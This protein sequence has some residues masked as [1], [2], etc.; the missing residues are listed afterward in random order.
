MNRE[1]RG[2]DEQTGEESNDIERIKKD[3]KKVSKMLSRLKTSAFIKKIIEICKGIMHCKDFL[4]KLDQNKLLIGCENG[5]LDLETKL[6]RAG[7]PDDFISFSTKI[8]YKEFKQDD[9]D[10]KEFEDFCFKIFPNKNRR[11]YFLD[12][13]CIAMQGGNIN[14]K[15]LAQTG[16]GNNGKSVMTALIEKCFGDYVIKFPREMIIRGKGNSSSQARPELVRVKGRRFAILQEVASN[17]EL[18]VGVVKELTGND[19]FF[20]RGMYKDGGEITPMFTLMMQCNKLP[21]IP[22]HDQATWNRVRV[23]F[24]ESTFDDEAPENKEEQIDKRHFE[25]DPEFSVKIPQ[26]SQVMLWYLFNRFIN[27]KSKKIVEPKEVTDA[28]EEYRNDCDIY[29]Q[30][31]SERINKMHINSPDIHKQTLTIREVYADFIDWYHEN[32][33]SY[34]KDKIGLGTFRQN[35]TK[36]IPVLTKTPKEND[37][38]IY[39]Y[40]NNKIYGYTFILGDDE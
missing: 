12:F 3:T 15:F 9:D 37:K 36:N 31:V 40:F 19:S 33:P 26:L 7:R 24:Y 28:T 20:A 35:I 27:L 25:A 14:K 21:K 18:N 22:A 4:I 11:D 6:F 16:D 34:S 2:E 8:V 29:M 38:E 17:E 39:G 32:H 1:H 5:V 10:V 23:L 30:Y 13:L